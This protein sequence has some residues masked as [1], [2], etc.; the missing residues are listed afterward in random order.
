MDEE[1]D[2]DVTVLRRGRFPR[3]QVEAHHADRFTFGHRTASARVQRVFDEIGFCTVPGVL[4]PS[5]SDEV[6]FAAANRRLDQ[7]HFRS[8]YRLFLLA[9]ERREATSARI[10][11]IPSHLK[12]STAAS[13]NMSQNSV[14]ARR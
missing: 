10:D 1:H 9:A 2:D 14:P 3:D 12:I 6:E 5:E 7:K 11:A 13:R 4:V 8:A